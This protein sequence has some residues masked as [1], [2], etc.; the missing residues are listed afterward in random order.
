VKLGEGDQIS[1]AFLTAAGSGIFA[2]DPGL[3]DIGSAPH[4]WGYGDC[5]AETIFGAGTALHT[6]V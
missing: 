3:N 2:F 6:P 4:P 5:F 1:A